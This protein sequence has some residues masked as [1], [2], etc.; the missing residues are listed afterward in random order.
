MLRIAGSLNPVNVNLVA[1]GDT[2]S[3]QLRSLREW[4]S[5]EDE[6]RGTITLL[7]SP[8]EPDRLGPTVDALQ[9]VAGSASTALAAGLIAWLRTRVGRVR[10]V[11]KSADGK[12]IEVDASTVHALDAAGLSALTTELINTIDAATPAIS[13][14]SEPEDPVT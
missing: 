6:L 9:V 1:F 10:I 8:P 11:L 12:E 14:G 5:H 3:D 4:L 13:G 2:P 7:E